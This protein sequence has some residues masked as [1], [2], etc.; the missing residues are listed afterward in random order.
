MNPYLTPKSL[1]TPLHGELPS[2]TR[3]TDKGDEDDDH[4]SLP[5]LAPDNKTSNNLL[6]SLLG[7]GS[8]VLVVLHM[9]GHRTK[10]LRKAITKVDTI[11]TSTVSTKFPLEFF[12]VM[13]DQ[14]VILVM[15]EDVSPA[16]MGNLNRK[17]LTVIPPIMHVPTQLGSFQ[18]SLDNTWP[19]N[20]TTDATSARLWAFVSEGARVADTALQDFDKMVQDF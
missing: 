7:K 15:G 20:I 14:M 18:A 16:A 13:E 11:P 1:R 8:P 17:P 10:P 2:P 9:M 3:L 12:H 5:P 4:R 19:E 6:V